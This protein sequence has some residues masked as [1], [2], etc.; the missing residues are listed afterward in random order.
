MT[1]PSVNVIVHASGTEPCSQSTPT[2]EVVRPSSRCGIDRCDREW[3]GSVCVCVCVLV[4]GGWG[5]EWGGGGGYEAEE[6]ERRGGEGNGD[7]SQG[8]WSTRF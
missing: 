2:L 1:H 5:W 6:E 7:S 3:E 4:G 8:K